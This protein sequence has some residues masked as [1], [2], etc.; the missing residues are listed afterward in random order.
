MLPGVS[1]RPI[2]ARACVVKLAFCGDDQLPGLT[3][4]P[5]RPTAVASPN[6]TSCALFSMGAL[7]FSPPLS[8]FYARVESTAIDV[9]QWGA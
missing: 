3:N 4:R 8:F 9:T 1:G 5:A 7:T 2:S 6:W